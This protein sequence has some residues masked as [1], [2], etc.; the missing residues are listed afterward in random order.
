MSGA[1]CSPSRAGMLCGRYQERFGHELN[2][3]PG[4][5]KGGMSLKEKTFGDRLKAVGYKTGMIGK[6]HLGYPA[7]Y[8]PNKRGFDHFYG[9]LQGAR[10][11]F[12]HEKNITSSCHTA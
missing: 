3:P 2:I 8:H 7:E 11:Y 6:W 5:M 4:Y 9:L 1:V 10:G 12:P